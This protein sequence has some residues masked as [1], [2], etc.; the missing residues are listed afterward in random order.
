MISRFFAGAFGAAP[1]T[2]V[3]A[4][5][6][7]M[8]NN[9]VRGVAVAMFSAT[10]MG[11]PFMGPFIGGF[12][13]KSSIGWRWTAYIPAILGFATSILSFFF[14]EESYGPVILVNK[15]SELRRLTRNWGIH[16]KQEEIEVDIQELLKKNL[17][18]PLRILFTEPIVLL[19]TIYMS[20][21]YG[22]LY[23]N[24][25]AYGIV[26]G[27]IYGFSLGVSGLP[28][29]ALLVGVLIAFAGII[30]LN[31]G[32]VKKLKANNNIPVPEWRLPITM[33]GG[34]IFAAGT[35][36]T[37]QSLPFPNPAPQN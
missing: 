20:F 11:G 23:L 18:R 36:P 27:Q 25:T 13:T 29:F 30:L 8:F 33:V 35:F 34:V 21:I 37:L 17:S 16:A 24:L 28:Y 7:D 19:I 26:F 14:Q 22:I 9:E 1:L 3:A 32:Y 4:V 12:I 10:I 31:K 15:A 5:F 2:I 6:A